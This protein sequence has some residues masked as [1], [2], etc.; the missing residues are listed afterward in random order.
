MILPD[1]NLL[2]YAY[3]QSSPFHARAKAWCERIMS[4]PR[5]KCLSPC[6]TS[7]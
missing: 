6:A 2:L 4:G 3:D 5:R 1:A 7:G